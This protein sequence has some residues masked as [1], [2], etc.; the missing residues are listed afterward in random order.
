MQVS[1]A[2]RE[3]EMNLNNEDFD[4]RQQ[5]YRRV[6]WTQEGLDPDEMEAKWREEKEARAKERRLRLK[7]E[8]EERRRRE[9][10]LKQSVVAKDSRFQKAATDKKFKK[11]KFVAT[12]KLD[13]LVVQR[14]TEP[15]KVKGKNPRKKPQLKKKKSQ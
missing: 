1:V 10:E 4:E 9:E 8:N 13:E 7:Q 14:K 11:A 6:R 15:I 5:R 3:A 2:R 12:E